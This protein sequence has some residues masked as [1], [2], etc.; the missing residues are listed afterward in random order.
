MPPASSE[1]AAAPAEEPAA[2]EPKFDA[3]DEI[4]RRLR[5]LP[6]R[7]IDSFRILD[8]DMS[9][10]IDQREFRIG[11]LALLSRKRSDIPPQEDDID[12]LFHR[13]DADGS[14]DISLKELDKALRLGLAKETTLD[15]TLD[16]GSAGPIE[17]S[18]K[19]AKSTKREAGHKS[20]MKKLLEMKAIRDG[21]MSPEDAL[22]LAL[23]E[24]A[25]R[26]MDLFR[27]WDINGDGHIDKHE[28]VTGVNHFGFAGGEEA[29]KLFEKWDVDGSGALS[30]SELNNVLR[31]GE[32]YKGGGW[33]AQLAEQHRFQ[34]LTQYR[35]PYPVKLTSRQNW[36]RQKTDGASGI[37]V[38]LQPARHKVDAELLRGTLKKA[39]RASSP[40]RE[41]AA[42]ILGSPRPGSASNW[43]RPSS[44]QLRDEI[45]SRSANVKE[46]HWRKASPPRGP[47]EISSALTTEVTKAQQIHMQ[48]MKKLIQERAKEARMKCAPFYLD[49]MVTRIFASPLAAGDD[50]TPALQ[51]PPQRR[52]RSARARASPRGN[53]PLG[54][55]ID[56]TR[57]QPEAA[58][59][60][61]P[62]SESPRQSAKPEVG[63][64]LGMLLKR[65]S[66]SDL[67][68]A[69]Q[70]ASRPTPHPPDGSR[71]SAGHP[72]SR[73][74]RPRP[75]T[76]RHRPKPPMKVFLDDN[77]IEAAGRAILRKAG[78]VIGELEADCPD[79]PHEDNACSEQGL[80]SRGRPP[81]NP[82]V[83]LEDRGSTKAKAQKMRE[84]D[85]LINSPRQIF[86]GKRLEPSPSPRKA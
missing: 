13:L 25:V 27:D 52:P 79:L 54:I 63:L 29:A 3:A 78:E 73:A 22:R 60:T 1:A 37:V 34:A 10:A 69:A 5:I 64:V 24:N 6:G 50:E 77:E 19:N 68:A 46:W 75:A 21:F 74:M 71:A 28:F 18:A 33:L 39:P 14:G 26:V 43:V 20:K 47:K 70:K 42:K 16:A 45:R 59:G 2:E 12:I 80:T 40:E 85:A 48:E 53:T 86:G 83:V 8:E 58:Q 23:N 51:G 44:A 9:G 7:V 57:D 67:A 61:G 49:P 36:S 84:K 17:L 4:L 35:A 55:R 76:A 30:F 72:R 66:W 65:A 38:H 62:S 56:P 15:K 32:Q 31:R 41:Q 81:W 82:S 11:V